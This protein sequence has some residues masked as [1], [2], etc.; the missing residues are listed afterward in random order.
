MFIFSSKLFELPNQFM[1]E[2][3]PYICIEFLLMDRYF[4]FDGIWNFFM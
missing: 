1:L 2:A 3:T 4:L